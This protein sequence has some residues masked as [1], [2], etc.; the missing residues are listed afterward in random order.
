MERKMNVEAGVFGQY[1]LYING[2]DVWTFDP[3]E[4]A[5]EVA[6]AVV[7]GLRLPEADAQRAARIVN[8]A[9]GNID[10]AELSEAVHTAAV[11]WRMAELGA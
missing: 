4:G 7:S 5:G 1:D 2:E 3:S 10:P 11:V 9:M 6:D 8:D